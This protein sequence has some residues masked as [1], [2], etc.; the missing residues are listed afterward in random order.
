MT[1]CGVFDG[2][3]RDGHLVSSKVRDSLPLKLLSSLIS[4]NSKHNATTTTTTYFNWN[5]K[6]KGQDSKEDH[7]VEDKV[8]SLWREAFLKSYRAMDK[9]L[10][11]H[12]K[13]DSFYSGS[14]AV[15]LVKQVFLR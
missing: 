11:S 3:G 9:E 14:T 5:L 4:S 7:S 6:S 13:L 8:D 2:H 15:T 12:R 1:F 10:R